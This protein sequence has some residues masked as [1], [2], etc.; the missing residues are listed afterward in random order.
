METPETSLTKFA[1]QSLKGIYELL[2]INI[3]ECKKTGKIDVQALLN[4]LD[5]QSK[6]CDFLN[7]FFNQQSIG[8]EM[9]DPTFSSKE[10]RLVLENI[11]LLNADDVLFRLSFTENEKNEFNTVLCL[12]SRTGINLAKL[13]DI[14]KVAGIDLDNPSLPPSYSTIGSV[15]LYQFS[16][17][18]NHKIEIAKTAFRVKTEKAWQLPDLERFSF[19]TEMDISVDYPLMSEKTTISG[20]ICGK[21]DF[22][23][24]GMIKLEAKLQEEIIL[25]ITSERLNISKLMELCAGKLPEIIPDT[26]TDANFCLKWIK[27]RKQWETHFEA[28]TTCPWSIHGHILETTFKLRF[29]RQATKEGKMQ[30]GGELGISAINTLPINKDLALKTFDLNFLK[31]ADESDWSL[32]GDLTLSLFQSDFKL[33]AEIAGSS[34]IKQLK[35][36]SEEKQGK[37][38]IIGLENTYISGLFFDL[39][40]TEKNDKTEITGKLSADLLFPGDWTLSAS[41]CINDQSLELTVEA[42]DV[43]FKKV[44][45]AFGISLPDVLPQT[46]LNLNVNIRKRDNTWS[47]ALQGDG[48][49][50]WNINGN[51]LETLLDF[52]LQSEIDKDKKMLFGGKLNIIA[53]NTILI[54]NEIALRKLEF[55]INKEKDKP[56]WSMDGGLIARLFDIDCELNADFAGGSQS[57][58]LK[59]VSK[60]AQ[61]N[62]PLPGLENTFIKDFYFLLQFCREGK[63]NH[64]SGDFSGMLQLPDATELGIIS[65]VDKSDFSLN[66]H[67]RNLNFSKIC[68]LLGIELPEVL[69]QTTLDL[70]VLLTKSGQKWEIGLS[71]NGIMVWPTGNANLET[72]LDFALQCETGKDKKPLFGGKL[73]IFSQNSIPVNDD[74]KLQSA[75]FH[76][77]KEKDSEEWILGGGITTS[78]YD[79]VCDLEAELK[80]GKESQQLKLTSKKAQGDIPIPGLTEVAIKDFFL[81][82]MLD[83]RQ[84]ENCI[85]GKLSGKIQLPAQMELDIDSVVCKDNLTLNI[86]AQN[87]DFQEIATVLGINLPDVLPKVVANIGFSLSKNKGNWKTSMNGEADFLWPIADKELETAIKFALQ[88]ETQEGRVAKFGGSLEVTARNMVPVNDDILLKTLNFH[89]AKEKNNDK[90]IMDGGVCISLCQTDF[91]LD[92]TYEGSPGSQ[93]I[94]LNSSQAKGNILI[95]GLK[96]TSIKDLLFSLELVRENKTS[97]FSGTLQAVMQLP[98][99]TTLAVNSSLSNNKLQLKVAAKDIKLSTLADAL[100]ID[101]PD[102]IPEIEASTEFNTTKDKN[103]WSFDF[104]FKTNAIWHYEKEKFETATEI[105]L[106]SSATP[107]GR[108]TFGSIHFEADST[109]KLIDELQIRNFKLDM[110]KD[111]EGKWIAGG[112]S[113][114]FFFNQT[115]DLGAEYITGTNEMLKLYVQSPGSID[116]VPDVILLKPSSVELFVSKH[117]N[118]STQWKLSCN[119]E[120]DIADVFKLGGNLSVGTDGLV[121]TPDHSSSCIKLKVPLLQPLE[122]GIE[123]SLDSLSVTKENPVVKDGARWALAAQTTLTISGLPKFFDDFGITHGQKIAFSANSNGVGLTFKDT[124]LDTRVTLP[125]ISLGEG[126]YIELSKLGTFRFKFYNL[127]IKLG[128]E[129]SVGMGVGIAAPDE[130]NNLFGTDEKQ[131]PLRKYFVTASEGT[132]DFYFKLGYLFSTKSFGA[133]FQIESSPFTMIKLED[134]ANKAEGDESKV[135]K[136]DFGDMGQICF[137]IPSISFDSKGFGVNNCKASG[138]KSL[139]IPLRFIKQLLTQIIHAPR[140]VV[141]L[142][143]DKLPLADVQALDAKGH[144]VPEELLNHLEKS[145]IKVPKEVREAITLIA[146]EVKRLPKDLKPYLQSS[147]PDGFSVDISISMSTVEIKVNVTDPVRM[148]FPTM[149]GMVPM[150]QGITFRGFSLGMLFGGNMFKTTIDADFDQFDLVSLAAGLLIPEGFII[151]VCRDFKRKT[152]IEKLLMYIPIINISGVPVPIPVPVFYDE[153]GIEYMGIEGIGLQAHACFK[154]PAFDILYLLKFINS[155][156]DFLTIPDKHLLEIPENNDLTFKLRDCYLELPKY[157]INDEDIS[158]R[159]YGGQGDFFTLSFGETMVELFNTIKFMKLAD[160]VKAIPKKFRKSQAKGRVGFLGWD[161]EIDWDIEAG[162]GSLPVQVST[163]DEPDSI[164]AS[165]Y[166][167][168]VTPVAGLKGGFLIESSKSKGFRSSYNMKGDLLQGE[169]FEAEMRGEIIIDT[170]RPTPHVIVSDNSSLLF[171]GA[172]VFSQSLDVEYSEKGL[173]LDGQFC[174]F[175]KGCIVQ[176]SGAMTGMF[177]QETFFLAGKTNLTIAGLTFM[178]FDGSVSSSE[179]S[180]NGSYIGQTLSLRA[181]D[182]AGKYT[183][184]HGTMRLLGAS[185]DLKVDVDRSDIKNSSFTY[186]YDLPGFIHVDAAMRPISSGGTFNAQYMGMQVI[187]GNLFIDSNLVMFHGELNFPAKGFVAGLFGSMDGKVDASGITYFG[188]GSFRIGPMIMTGY[189]IEIKPDHFT[190]SG[191]FLGSLLLLKVYDKDYRY[192][193]MEGSIVILGCTLHML[194]SIDRMSL[195]NNSVI[196]DYTIPGILSLNGSMKP[197]GQNGHFDA[198]LFGLNVISGTIELNATSIGIKD[199]HLR[200]GLIDFSLSGSIGS[201]GLYAAGTWSFGIQGLPQLRATIVI[202]NGAPGISIDV[203][204]LTSVGGMICLYDNQLSVLFSLT[205]LGKTTYYWINSTIN[206]STSRPQN[207]PLNDKD[208]VLDT[209]WARIIDSKNKRYSIEEIAATIVRHYNGHNTD[210]VADLLSMKYCAT[211]HDYKTVYQYVPG[212]KNEEFTHWKL[213]FHNTGKDGSFFTQLAEGYQGLSNGDYLS[214]QINKVE[215]RFHFG[216]TQIWK[217][218]VTA[219]FDAPGADPIKIRF[220]ANHVLKTKDL[221]IEKMLKKKGEV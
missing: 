115:F 96:G 92:A 186:F 216:S 98:G 1:G 138:L 89:L 76:F 134:S 43:D 205:I 126:E 217:V 95:P 161:F 37:I 35:L 64:L 147:I 24:D 146:G 61:G 168:S 127:A 145:G 44:A 195:S 28:S 210:K 157:I 213:T 141:D 71:G 81:D 111:K 139:G 219:H 183:R 198:S 159:R 91:N 60:Q 201:N 165:I 194:I 188:N 200:L 114:L 88:S 39:D 18:L 32:K 218:D 79:V 21:Q 84:K 3:E 214:N 156:K 220:D 58:T 93:K 101:F 130:L 27:A 153:L 121:Y 120:L 12:S 50:I 14:L 189:T 68:Q 171:L 105:K 175:P 97:S 125:D 215:Y 151:P 173:R 26:T 129:I 197:I 5:I 104:D 72:K 212:D 211:L 160:L 90:W 51:N 94:T 100:G 117:K 86:L 185:I 87:L 123:I 191:L 25:K 181:I 113:Q 177:G 107:K 102:A 174:L 41:S 142:L 184:L 193:Q 221:L 66:I 22:G 155:I 40:L 148:L 23:D 75:E 190:A 69:P 74:I 122:A 67:A 106:T 154:Q 144:F 140:E 119:G 73:D 54:N 209:K 11:K 4:G 149:E 85:T 2:V 133:E 103:G 30:Y 16:V 62:I 15:D 70:N 124:L 77:S 208:E 179:I 80:G 20:S 163:G 166:G 164:Y 182:E 36:Q 99:T 202:N 170:S 109:F 59:L 53:N 57:Q 8:I 82:L 33:R 131:R 180:F 158:H 110:S 118:K 55:H 187:S 31:S 150:L 162:S 47:T 169:I 132:V 56:D 112:S 29:D 78:I 42:K 63:N 83:H 203:F 204:G 17:E 199:A 137:T 196:I 135:W 7:S 10:V 45:N 19:H 176:A 178:G 128:K 52:A 34:T 167:Y 48:K 6:L 65:K 9:G 172:K 206:S 38:A 108:S 46:V 136:C 152:I 116:L 13:A 143:P 49:M 207:W 192:T